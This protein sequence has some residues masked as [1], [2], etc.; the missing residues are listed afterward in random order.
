MS[1]EFLTDPFEGEKPLTGDELRDFRI[2]A[3]LSRS[4]LEKCTHLSPG[5]VRAVENGYLRLHRW[6][7]AKLRRL[8]LSEMRNRARAIAEYLQSAESPSP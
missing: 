6:E 4:E 1:D 2:L 8:L 5:R 7:S 3:G